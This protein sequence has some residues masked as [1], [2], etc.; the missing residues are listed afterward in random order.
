MLALMLNVLGSPMAW[1]QWLGADAPV[2]AAAM[3][4]GME[5]ACH[6]EEAPT[7][8]SCCESGD[9]TC[10]APALLVLL[11]VQPTR[12][13]PASLGAPRDLSALPSRPLDDALRPPIR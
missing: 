1:G 2:R 11:T 7:P 9:C 6:G 10:A 5:S 3:T 8:M 13:S 4:S 12:S